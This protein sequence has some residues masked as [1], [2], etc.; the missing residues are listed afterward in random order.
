MDENREDKVDEK[1]EGKQEQNQERVE[2]QTDTQA[3][4]GSFDLGKVIEDAKRVATGPAEFYRDMPQSGGFA[5]PCIFLLVMALIM[6]ALATLLS[7]FG[8]GHIGAMAIGFGSFILF[9]IMAVIG[10]FIGALVMFVIWKLMGSAK[11]YEAAYRCIAYAAVIYPI[12]PLVGWMPYL[13]TIITMGLGMY[14]MYVAT[15]EVH[16][17]KQQ[18]AQTV[19]GVLAAV[20]ILMQLSGEYTARNIQAQMEESAKEWQESAEKASKA[21]EEMSKNAEDMTPEEA[22]KALGEFFKGLSDAMPEEMKQQMEEA[23]KEAQREAQSSSAEAI[24]SASE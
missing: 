2:Q 14:L 22:G 18:T 3:Q 4:G 8:M 13:G 10:S 20:L 12:T 19:I 11:D 5:E 9:P 16:Q 21:F 23:Q 7:L 6:G 24:D 15:I 17:I 1:E